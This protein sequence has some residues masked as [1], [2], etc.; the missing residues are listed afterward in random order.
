M[1]VYSIV[2]EVDKKQWVCEMQGLFKKYVESKNL[3]IK[4][5]DPKGTEEMH[6][7]IDHLE[8]SIQEIFTNS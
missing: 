1:D 8:E 4:H 2:K 7:Q 3:K 5:S 6:R